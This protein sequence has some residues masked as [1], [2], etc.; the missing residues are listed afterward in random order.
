MFSYCLNNPVNR[1]DPT[2]AISLWYF[3]IIDSDMGFIHRA[4]VDH[5]DENYSGIYTERKLSNFGRADI[6]QRSTGAV[7]EVKHA[8]VNPPLRSATAQLQAYTYVLVN[9]EINC[10][11]QANAFSGTFY[12]QCGIYSYAIDYSTPHYG[13]ILYTVTELDNFE[14]EYYRVYVPKHEEAKKRASSRLYVPVYSTAR[15]GCGAFLASALLGMFMPSCLTPD[16]A[17]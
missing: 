7:W 13:V 3:L 9:D 10:L 16:Y 15:G 8:G 6:V 5:I 1:I 4:V 17:T 2:G 12:I 11:G 14:G